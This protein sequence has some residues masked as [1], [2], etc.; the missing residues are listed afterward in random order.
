METSETVTDIHMSLQ[1]TIDIE[2]RIVTFVI[3]SIPNV[4]VLVFIIFH[5]YKGF[6]FSSTG[7]IHTRLLPS[8]W[9]G[10]LIFIGSLHKA[11]GDG[12]D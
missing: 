3:C 8:R 1:L 4:K 12:K 6:S 11:R 9:Q 5:Y 2:N 10:F 7:I